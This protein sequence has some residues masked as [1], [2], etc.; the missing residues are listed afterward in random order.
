MQPTPPNQPPQPSQPTGPGYPTQPNYPYP[1]SYPP[2]AGYPAPPSQPMQPAYPPQS[3]PPYVPPAPYAP[4]PEATPNARE[5]LFTR[6]GLG[7]TILSA[8]A[9]LVYGFL[10]VSRSVPLSFLS[11]LSGL[12]DLITRGASIVGALALFYGWWRFF[13]R[14]R[15]ASRPQ[16]TQAVP[17]SQY[18]GVQPPPAPP[19][20]SVRRRAIVGCIFSLLV[21]A[22]SFS[23]TA[24]F[25][26]TYWTFGYHLSSSCNWGTNQPLSCSFQLTNDPSSSLTFNWQATTDPVTGATFSPSSGTLSPGDTASISMTAGSYPCPLEVIFL[27]SANNANATYTWNDNDAC[28]GANISPG[29]S[30]IAQQLAHPLTLRVPRLYRPARKH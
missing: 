3:A 5:R 4:P 29:A 30:P 23:A 7:L 22:G 15:G 11:F 10:I 12:G 6:L 13:S 18:P 8:L 17:P 14:V 16:N 2:Q 24:K 19:S 9:S 28:L 1:P 21:L 20:P 26:S 27:D 25:T